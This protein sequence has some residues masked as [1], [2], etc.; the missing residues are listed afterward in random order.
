MLNLLPVRNILF[1]FLLCL[2]V[3]VLQHALMPMCSGHPPHREAADAATAIRTFPTP[4]VSLFLFLGLNSR[5]RT[6]PR[7]YVARR[8]PL[9]ETR[10]HTAQAAQRI[11]PPRH[12]ETSSPHHATRPPQRPMMMLQLIRWGYDRFYTLVQSL[13]SQGPVGLQRA[14]A[15]S[16]SL[17]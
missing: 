6:A 1:R 2:M 9:I 14:L 16:K 4:A 12:T 17:R 8:R 7:H 10:A 3:S 11:A 13:K 5:R 15:G